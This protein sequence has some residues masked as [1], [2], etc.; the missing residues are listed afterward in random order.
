M[1]S[2]LFDKFI[3]L[4]PEAVLAVGE[5]TCSFVTVCVVLLNC[6]R[7]KCRCMRH[8]GFCCQCC[9][10]CQGGKFHSELNCFRW[11]LFCYLND[12]IW[13]TEN[14]PG[15]VCFDFSTS[16]AN[17]CYF[18]VHFSFIILVYIPLVPNDL[19][20]GEGFPLPFLCL[21]MNLRNS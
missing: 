16:L 12:I 11:R 3:L 4:E 18:Q 14:L 21:F 19:L 6:S 17:F 13:G 15:E 8:L 9:P 10:Y 20:G 1:V 5:G 7:K 2:A